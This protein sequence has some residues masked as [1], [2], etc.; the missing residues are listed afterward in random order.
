M[1]VTINRRTGYHVIMEPVSSACVYIM[2]SLLLWLQVMELLVH[3][4]KRVKSRPKVLLPVVDLIAQFRDPNVSP[5]VT[6]CIARWCNYPLLNI[7]FMSAEI[8]GYCFVQMQ[9]YQTK[10]YNHVICI[11][12]VNKRSWKVTNEERYVEVVPT[13]NISQEVRQIAAVWK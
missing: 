12:I 5:F 11:Y 1:T 8:T 6:V 7:C 2:C 9:V 13:R 3:I 10:Y 4:N